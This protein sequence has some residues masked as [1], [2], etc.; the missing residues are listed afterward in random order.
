MSYCDITLKKSRS[1]ANQAVT[2]ISSRIQVKVR[3]LG[4]E[5]G[6]E[7]AVNTDTLGP[8]RNKTKR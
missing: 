1:I 5:S 6:C 4:V 2:Q 7:Q 8:K 3:S